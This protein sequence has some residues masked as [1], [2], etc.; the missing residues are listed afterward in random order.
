M[1]NYIGQLITF[2]ATLIAVKGGT[3]DESKQG[4]KKITLTGFAS[5]ILALLGI[6]TSFVITYQSD[7]ESRMKSEQ[8]SEAVQNTKEAN[9]KVKELEVQLLAYKTILKEVRT[10][11]ERQPQQ[12]MAQYV[13]LDP[14]RIWHAP[15]LI[16]SGSIIKF[17]GFT[18]DLVLRYGNEQE[19]IPAGEGGSHPIEIAIIGHSGQGMIWSVENR[20]NNFC[21]GKVFV[22]S[23]PRT[24]SIDWSWVEERIKKIDK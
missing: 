1:F 21:H 23:T 10:E 5:I 24:R 14:G 22:E 15:N 16:Y 12:V 13:P 19:I 8:L 9:E 6:V 4:I 3:W 7:Q 17:Y 20:T 2:I 18:S 11:S